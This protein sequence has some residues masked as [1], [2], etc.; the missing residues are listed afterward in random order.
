MLET[1]SQFYLRIWLLNK[2]TYGLIDGLIPKNKL[3]VLTAL[4]GFE[5]KT[6]NK[7]KQ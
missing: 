7:R 5:K 2:A 6:Q 4:N 1:D 3:I